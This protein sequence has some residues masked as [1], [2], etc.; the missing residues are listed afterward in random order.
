MARP[1]GMVRPGKLRMD[2]GRLHLV[3]MGS[4]RAVTAKLC[5]VL[6]ITGNNLKVVMDSQLQIRLHFKASLMLADTDKQDLEW[7]IALIIKVEALEVL[8]QVLMLQPILTKAQLALVFINLRQGRA[9]AI[10][11]KLQEL[12]TVSFIYVFFLKCFEVN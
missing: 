7:Q 11:T 8:I 12:P 2:Q 5:L 10:P 1:R 4:P 6:Q 3:V 9:V